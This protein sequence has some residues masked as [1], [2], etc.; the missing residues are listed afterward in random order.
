MPVIRAK[1]FF[2]KK[3]SSSSSILLFNVD[4]NRKSVMN[5]KRFVKLF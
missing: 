5:L 3:N 2:K 4:K 1:F